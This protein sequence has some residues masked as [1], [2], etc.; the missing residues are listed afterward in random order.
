MDKR[1]KEILH[2]AIKDFIE[3]GEYITSRKIYESYDFGIKPAMIRREL[4]AL[5]NSG[6]LDQVHTSSGRYPTNK[7]YKDFV[8]ELVDKIE[9]CESENKNIEELVNIDF[10]K[11]KDDILEHLAN[12]L[13]DYLNVL[14]ACY[15][16]EKERLYNRGLRKLCANLSV[17]DKKHLNEILKDFELMKD[18]IRSRENWWKKEREWP[19]YFIGPS[20]VTESDL[21]AVLAHKISFPDS[22]IVI[23]TVGPKAMDYKKSINALRN[24]EKT[25]Q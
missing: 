19:Q 20:P 16:P 17:D 22:D 13:A 18:R 6:Y 1:R 14:S 25:L 9:K 2:C 3:S 12:S 8:E 11:S 5:D 15:E 24:L 4:N 21:L 23:I 7:A 10:R